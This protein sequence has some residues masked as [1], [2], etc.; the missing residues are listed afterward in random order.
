MY[1][2]IVHARQAG[3][4]TAQHNSYRLLPTFLLKHLLYVCEEVLHALVRVNSASWQEMQ[5]V[6]III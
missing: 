1:I 5:Q 6:V 3:T 2:L 4:M